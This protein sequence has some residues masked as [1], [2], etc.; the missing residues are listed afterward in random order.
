MNCNFS[1]E[2]LSARRCETIENESSDSLW[3]WPTFVFPGI[4]FLPSMSDLLSR[5]LPP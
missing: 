2:I 5:N 1:Y 3:W 4:N